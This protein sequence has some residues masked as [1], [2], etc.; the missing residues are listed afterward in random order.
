MDRLGRAGTF[1]QYEEIAQERFSAFAKDAFTK[2][3]IEV[4][5]VSEGFFHTVVEVIS[6][7]RTD[8]RFEFDGSDELITANDEQVPVLRGAIEAREG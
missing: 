8:L 6:K 3:G 2:G 4:G 7:G 1:F 5:S